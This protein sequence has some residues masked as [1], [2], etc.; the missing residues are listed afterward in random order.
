M[1]NRKKED[2]IKRATSE[3]LFFNRIKEH[4]LEQV[5]KILIKTRGRFES[6]KENFKDKLLKKIEGMRHNSM[7]FD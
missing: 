4:R 5:R 7:T 6:I 3:R 1:L 2:E